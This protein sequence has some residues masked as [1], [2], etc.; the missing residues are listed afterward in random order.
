MKHLSRLSP[1]NCSTGQ[2][3][4]GWSFSAAYKSSRALESTF[5]LA[6]SVYASLSLSLPFFFVNK[7]RS[8]L[9][10]LVACRVYTSITRRTLLKS[11]ASSVVDEI[12]GSIVIADVSLRYVKLELWIE[13]VVRCKTR[14]NFLDTIRFCLIKKME[15]WKM[16]GLEGWIR[17]T[18]FIVFESFSNTNWFCL[19]NLRVF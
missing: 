7:A 17:L 16:G 5:Q 1:L 15:I 19:R 13:N 14:I 11:A 9:R 10:V 6:V 18:R 8:S 2:A 4:I 12:R 3:W